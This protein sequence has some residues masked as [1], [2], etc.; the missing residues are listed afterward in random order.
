[1]RRN[2][3]GAEEARGVSV[4]LGSPTEMNFLAH[5]TNPVES[6][7]KA[8]DFREKRRRLIGNLILQTWAAIEFPAFKEGVN[9]SLSNL[10][11]EQIREK[12]ETTSLFI[13]IPGQTYAGRDTEPDHGWCRG[14][15]HLGYRGTEKPGTDSAGFIASTWDMVAKKLPRQS[16]SRRENC[17]LRMSMPA[18]GQSPWRCLPKPS[19][20]ISA[21][22]CAGSFLGFPG[23][24]P[25]GPISSLYGT[26]TTFLVC[27]RRKKSFLVCED[28]MAPVLSPVV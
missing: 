5:R 15:L 11:T 2:T 20:N 26:T 23:P 1:M 14:G 16:P 7:A 24:T 4:N 6:S 10:G 9:M 22:T 12:I 13:D 8:G 27:L 28:T 19:S 18:K 25:T 17:R 3:A 21:K